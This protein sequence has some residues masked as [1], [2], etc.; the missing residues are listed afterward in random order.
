MT[1]DSP[2]WAWA[3]EQV[4]RRSRAARAAAGTFMVRR[5]RGVGE[6]GW[7]WGLRDAPLQAAA[8]PGPCPAFMP[9]RWAGAGFRRIHRERIIPG[10][11]RQ[12]G[13]DLLSWRR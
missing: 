6:R 9:G 10:K 7:S 3:G 2:R 8:S 11:S 5:S 1:G 13:P 12:E 4:A